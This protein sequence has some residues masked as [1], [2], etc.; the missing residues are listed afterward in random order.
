MS[1]APKQRALCK[2][3]VCRRS[4]PWLHGRSRRNR[5]L[6][7][8]RIYAISL[9]QL[10]LISPVVIVFGLKDQSTIAGKWLRFEL[11]RLQFDH[12]P[13]IREVRNLLKYPAFARGV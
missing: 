8:L 1:A 11:K 4:P 3:R 13:A 5:S 10:T 6:P 12:Q 2:G 9:D 7:F